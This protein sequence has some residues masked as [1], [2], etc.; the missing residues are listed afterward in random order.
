MR[1]SAAGI[2]RDALFLPAV[3][4][5]PMSTTAFTSLAPRDIAGDSAARPAP[6]CA[7]PSIKFIRANG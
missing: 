5:K 3:A 6:R 2:N 7:P 4:D 1:L